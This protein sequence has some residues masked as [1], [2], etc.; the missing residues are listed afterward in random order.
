M[1]LSALFQARSGAGILVQTD[2]E[3]GHHGHGKHC[4]QVIL[5]KA[6]H[7]N[8]QCAPAFQSSICAATPTTDSANGAAQALRSFIDTGFVASQGTG[9][10][11]IA[12]DDVD[13]GAAQAHSR[14]M[15]AAPAAENNTLAASRWALKTQ[16]P[17]PTAS[18]QHAS[19]V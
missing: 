11:A 16:V 19:A 12:D 6:Q 15:E 14:H 2:M 9:T 3:L 10:H 17:G 5:R 7:M 4:A 8:E 18:N 13:A 1:F